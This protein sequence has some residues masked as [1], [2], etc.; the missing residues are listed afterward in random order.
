MQNSENKQNKPTVVPK[1]INKKN[2]FNSVFTVLK[3]FN[4]PQEKLNPISLDLIDNIWS[5][6]GTLA[7]TDKSLEW[8]N[9]I[10]SHIK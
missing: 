1:E 8:N 5:G 9:K 4:S 3:I 2:N 7:N 6:K 10:P